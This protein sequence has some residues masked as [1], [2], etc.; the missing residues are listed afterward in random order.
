MK[1]LFDQN[2]SYRLINK[3]SDLYPNAKQ[4]KELKL[5]DKT[6]IEIFNFAKNNNYHI[7]TFDVDFFDI[8]NL[9]GFP[10]KIIWIRTGNISTKHL[11]QLFKNK[12]E[13]IDQFIDAN[14]GCLEI[15][16]I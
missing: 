7:V 11:E 9:K 13:Q 14:F 5:E 10:P 12:K 1:L 4:V 16:D 6:D 8:S 3:I 15:F 2:I